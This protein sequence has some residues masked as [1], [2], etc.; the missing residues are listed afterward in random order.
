M[1]NS[2]EFGVFA[3]YGATV[4]NN[5]NNNNNNNNKRRAMS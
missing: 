4:E 1:Y 5:N 2:D 3:P